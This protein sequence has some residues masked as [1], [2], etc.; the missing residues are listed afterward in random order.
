MTPTSA[1]MARVSKPTAG[2]GKGPSSSTSMPTDEEPRP[3]RLL[4]HVA[5]QPRVLADHHAMAMVAAVEDLAGRHADAHGDLGSHR[6]TVGAAAHTVGAEERAGHDC[7]AY[8]IADETARAWRVP[9]TSCTRTIAAPRRAASTASHT[10]AGSRSRG[11]AI[12]VSLP[13]KLLRD[14]PIRTG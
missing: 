3:Q 10:E 13:M 7:R 5:G 4:D 14:A 2:V 6:R 12:P 9:A 8:R 11:S 1:R